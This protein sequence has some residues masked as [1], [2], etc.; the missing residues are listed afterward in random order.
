M[1]KLELGRGSVRS[2]SWGP[3]LQNSRPQTLCLYCFSVIKFYFWKRVCVLSPFS[4]IRLFA[5]L[6]T[7]AQQVLYSWDSLGTNTGVGCHALLQEILPTQ[8]SI[9]LLSPALA[10]RFFT[11]RATWEAL[12]KE[13]VVLIY[14]PRAEAQADKAQ[15][16]W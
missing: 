11:T 10:G 15:L 14:T 8:E 16:L 4:C 1:R 6:W 13:H 7:V 12:G 3:W 2:G 9:S 5:A